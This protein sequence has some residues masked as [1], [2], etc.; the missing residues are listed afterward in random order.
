MRFVMVFAVAILSGCGQA[1]PT[2]AGGK[3]VSYWAQA[4]KDPDPKLRKTAA[5]KLGNVG[6]TDTTVAS[7]L[8]GALND[9]DPGVRCEVILAL[10]KCGPE[11]KDVIPDLA[12]MQKN[13]HDAKV[14]DYAGKALDKLNGYK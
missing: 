14:R 2:L 6:A 7:T 10:V 11:A 1:P 4:L 8:M 13:D 3:P 5:F 9:A 12:E